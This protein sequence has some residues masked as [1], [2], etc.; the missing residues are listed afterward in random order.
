MIGKTYLDL[1]NDVRVRMA[2]DGCL[3]Q[4]SP[5]RGDTAAASGRHFDR[6]SAFVPLVELLASSSIIVG[7]ESP[8]EGNYR[9]K[10]RSLCCVALVR[11]VVIVCVVVCSCSS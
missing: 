6:A 2:W 11:R 10:V 8:T 4:C 7:N 5:T 9:G 1:T 3:Q